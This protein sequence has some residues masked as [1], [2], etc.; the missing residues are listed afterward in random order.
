MSQAQNLYDLLVLG[1]GPAGSTA[2]IYAKRA[3]LKVAVLT[4]AQLGGQLTITPSIENFPSYSSISGADL[5]SRMNDQVNSLKIDVKFNSVEKIEKFNDFFKLSLDSSDEMFA[6]SVIIATGAKP[7][8]LSVPGEAEFFGKGVSYCA[9]CDGFFFRKKDVVVVGGGNTATE[10]AIF[11]SNIANSV[12]LVHRRDSLRAEKILVDQLMQNEKI[13][14]IWNTEI[15]EIKGSSRVESLILY[16]KIEKREYDFATNGLFVA[17]GYSPNSNNFKDFLEIDADGYIVT[18]NTKT[19]VPGIFAAGDIQDKFYKQ[20]IIAA[21][22][23]A[24]AAIEA[25]N[26]LQSLKF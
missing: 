17:V 23:G 2:A 10:E 14:V 9:T 26:W 21:G 24:I 7:R 11:L 4:G 22:S 12:T 19:S 18:Q 3:G 1:S 8:K 15:K 13:R 6:K 16:D 20:A 25:K 5:M